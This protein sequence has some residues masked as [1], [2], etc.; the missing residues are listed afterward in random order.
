MREETSHGRGRE[1]LRRRQLTAEAE[2]DSSCRQLWR[3][4]PS[5]LACAGWIRHDSNKA[6]LHLQSRPREV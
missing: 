2:M 1:G 5:W 4:E 6:A 3:R